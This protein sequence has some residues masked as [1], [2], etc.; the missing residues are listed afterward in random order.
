MARAIVGH[1]DG[2]LATGL[3]FHAYFSGPRI[4]RV[5]DQFLHD[6]SWPFHH[7]TSGYF[8]NETFV[9]NANSTRHISSQLGPEPL[10]LLPEF[11]L[12]NFA[13]FER[14][15]QV[16]QAAARPPSPFEI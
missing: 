4:D 13:L 16:A 6:R 7:L 15:F 2:L 12:G 5:F 8:T 3:D 10:G 11:G 9:E 1:D 14:G